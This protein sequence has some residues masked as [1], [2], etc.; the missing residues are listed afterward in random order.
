MI[1]RQ[2]PFYSS[3]LSAPMLSMKAIVSS[4]KLLARNLYGGTEKIKKT[5]VGIAGV[6]TE[7]RTEHLPNTGLGR[8]LG[9]QAVR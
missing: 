8:Y 7:I 6:P 1:M 4:I 9:R 2:V 5:P 3:M